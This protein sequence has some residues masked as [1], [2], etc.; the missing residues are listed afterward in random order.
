[1][2]VQ[3]DQCWFFNIKPG[4]EEEKL[5]HRHLFESLDLALQANLDEIMYI[6]SQD[7]TSNVMLI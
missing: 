3:I 5:G 7:Y 4:L 2:S 1:M 6:T